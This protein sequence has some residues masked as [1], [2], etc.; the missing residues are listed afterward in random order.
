MKDEKWADI[1]GYEGLYQISNFGRVKSL[2]RKVVN[3]RSGSMRIVN[4]MIMTPFDN[5]TG[6][7]AISLACER[8]R[9]NFYVHRLVGGAFIENPQNKKII[10]HIDYDTNNNSSDN[11]EW[12]SQKENIMHSV[13]HMKKPRTIS[14]SSTGIKYISIRKKTKFRVQIPNQKM[15]VFNS[16]EQAVAYKNQLLEGVV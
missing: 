5:G 14:Y 15:R 13:E 7:K 11:L 8:K 9:K 3:H 2:Q 1:K 6:Y 12:C 4:E 10:N 16:I